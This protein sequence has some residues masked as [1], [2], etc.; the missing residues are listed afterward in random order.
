M[1]A[2]F[3]RE[4]REIAALALA[5]A[6]GLGI[7]RFA[8]ALVLPDMRADLGWSYSDAGLMNASNAAGYL[9]GAL[10]ASR[11]IARFGGLRALKTGVWLCIASLIAC[12]LFRGPWPLNAARVLAGFGAALSFVSGGLLATRCAERA[13]AQGSLLLGAFYAGPGFGVLLSGAFV[14][15]LIEA[16]GRGGWRW[17]WAALAV[18]SLVMAIGIGRA[19][20]DEARSAKGNGARLK[21]APMA[22]ILFGYAMFGAGYIAYMT[23]MIAWVQGGAGGAA[24]SALFW[25]ALG[26]AGMATPWVWAGALRRLH[27]G[28]AFALTN[29]I[30]AAGAALPLLSPSL[31]A[32]FAS[33]ALFGCAFFA[34]VAST[35]AYVRRSLPPAQWAAGI[36]LLTVSFGVG[37]TF[38]PLAIGFLTDRFGGLSSGLWVSVGLLALAAL[39]GATQRDLPDA[40]P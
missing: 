23:F 29:A 25:C 4:A 20:A 32:L 30:T 11:V 13:P 9:G 16:L 33:A 14:P 40:S 26:A 8:Y 3:R 24:T 38:G 17:T 1:K 12:A 28:Y 22:R 35:T 34:V 27:H 5:P 10:I 37:Q 7:G 15:F 21:L 39:I 18:L 36:G 6:I 31:A 2:E 19:R